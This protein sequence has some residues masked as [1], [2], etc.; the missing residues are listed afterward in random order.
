MHAAYEVGGSLKT[1]MEVHPRMLQIMCWFQS[2]LGALAGR[3]V[4]LREEERGQAL[5]E[6]GLI[7]ALIAAVVI[8]TIVILGSDILKAFSS[9]T[10]QI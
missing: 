10:S 2:G 7:L 9:I 1:K 3:V 5:V 6:Y 4:T 8:G